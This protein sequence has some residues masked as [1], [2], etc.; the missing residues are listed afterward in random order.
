[1]LEDGIDLPRQA[2]TLAACPTCAIVVSNLSDGW[3]GAPALD[4]ECGDSQSWVAFGNSRVSGLWPSGDM[5]R[6]LER[7]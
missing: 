6:S 5:K 2:V 7:R 1:M 3:G 4:V